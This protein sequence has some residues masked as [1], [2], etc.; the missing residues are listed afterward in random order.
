MKY[1]EAMAT[2]EKDKWDEAV[3]EEHDCMEMLQVLKVVP[4]SKVPEDA[5]ILT[6]T[7]AMK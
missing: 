3:K 5:I 2:A 4:R 1:H 6:S 7:W